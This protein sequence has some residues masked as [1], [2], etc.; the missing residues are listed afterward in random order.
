MDVYVLH[1]TRNGKD[2]LSSLTIKGSNWKLTGKSPPLT[3]FPTF[4]AIIGW[5]SANLLALLYGILLKKRY[6]RIAY[7]DLIANPKQSIEL[8]GTF[9]DVD[10]HHIIESLKSDNV[11][12]T[13]HQVGGN[14]VKFQRRIRLLKEVGAPRDS[15]KIYQ[16]F[17]FKILAGWLQVYLGY[18]L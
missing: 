8:I 4:R 12:S 5:M 13:G 2:V 10:M 16:R 7:E 17:L 3:I 14:R 9:I 18:D 6:L 15:L 11:F 1:L